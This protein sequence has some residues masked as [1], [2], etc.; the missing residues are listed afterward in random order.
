MLI[1]QYIISFLFA[2]LFFILSRYY[3]SNKLKY[4]MYVNLIF[5]TIFLLFD[6]YNDNLFEYV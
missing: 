3:S 1:N 6:Y 2:L 4:I 5:G